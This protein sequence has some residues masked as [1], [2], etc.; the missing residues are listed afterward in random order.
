MRL[1]LP[2][3]TIQWVGETD[4]FLRIIDQTLLP[5]REAYLNLYTVD[6]LFDAIRQLKVRG[7]PAIGVAAAYGLSLVLRE[8]EENTKK[9]KD[10]LKRAAEKLRSAR[11]TAVNL[12]YGID[13][14]LKESLSFADSVSPQLLKKTV[15]ASARRLQQ[16]DERMCES[17]GEQGSQLI[18]DG[19][20]VLTNCNA[21]ALATCGIGTALA[22]VYT[23]VGQGRRVSVVCCETRPLLQGARLSTWELL[24]AKIPTTLICDNMA[25]AL[26]RQGKINAVFVGADR[27]AANG[28]IA[29]KIGTYPLA[30]L[31]KIHSIP[32]Y[33]VAP[34][35][36]FDLN[37]PSGEK[38]PI[39]ERPAEEVTFIQK[40]IRTAPE[41]VSVFNPAFDVTPAHLITAIVW[42]G[43]IISPPFEQTIK[44]VFKEKTLCR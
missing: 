2:F 11:P 1:S 35:S 17:L 13:R 39:E 26:M 10:E 33:V 32:F 41:G 43:G 9:L 28:D 4:G 7:A 14:V 8:A 24:K 37:T 22:C 12:F 38:I 18:K 23:A 30:C 15:L 44:G 21:G 27:I 19:Y 5:E 34:S 42:E 40:R 25:G 16:E 31:A 36:S 29:N 3:K 20:T 6:E